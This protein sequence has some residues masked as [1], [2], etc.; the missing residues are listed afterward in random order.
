MSQEIQNPK[1]PTMKNDTVSKHCIHMEQPVWDQAKQT[2]SSLG[3]STSQ[4]LSRLVAETSGHIDSG[5]L[6]GRIVAARRKAKVPHPMKHSATIVLLA[7]LIYSAAGLSLNAQITVGGNGSNTTDNT[8][9]SG[10]QTLTKVGS[11][12]VTLHEQ[13]LLHWRH[14]DQHRH[15]ANFEWLKYW[16][17]KCQLER[18]HAG[19]LRQQFHHYP[20][21]LNPCQFGPR[22]HKQFHP[23]TPRQHQWRRETH[24]QWSGRASS[25]RSIR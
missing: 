2:A 3:L 18:W 21:S 8:S 20:P 23:H 6:L 17:G 24:R 10:A 19:L 22:S 4:F 9:Y 13:Q 5:A 12:T 14:D 15:A 7:A 16:N 11:N 1:H 25:Y